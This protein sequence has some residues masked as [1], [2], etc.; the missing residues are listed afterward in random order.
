MGRIALGADLGGTNLRAALVDESGVVLKR[1]RTLT[2]QTGGAAAIIDAIAEIA[3]KC[4]KGAEAGNKVEGFLI[5]VPAVLDAGEGLIV[6]SPNLP[7]LNGVHITKELEKLLGVPVFVENDATA[8]TIGENWLGAS[9]GFSN[10]I[11]ITL[12]TGVGG[13]I[14]LDGK[15]LRGPDGTAGEVGHI[16][17]EPFGHPCGCGSIGCLEQY[18]SATAIVRIAKEW[19]HD[20]PD[21]DFH[22]AEDFS[23]D[24][25]YEAGKNGD[26]LAIAVFQ[27]M[28]FCLGVAISGLINVLNPEI[29]VI[30]GGA[31]A[32]WDLFIDKLRATVAERAFRRP[33]ERVNIVR[34]TLGDDAGILG[35]ASLVFSSSHREP[36][37]TQANA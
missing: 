19:A 32:G 11:G 29:V 33:A 35:A 10:S 7:V 20:Y 3:E 36:G 31:A 4:L 28:G 23:S 37:S 18:A 9:R 21:S 12:G 17:I 25:I 26:R 30:G 22:D 8:A 1:H 16:C 24:E 6:E 2:P 34:A 5:A 15:A 13:G 27:R 14:I